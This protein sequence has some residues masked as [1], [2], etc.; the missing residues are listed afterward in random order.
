MTKPIPD[1][2][3]TLTPHIVVTDGAQAIEFYKQAFGAQEMSR[4]MTPDGKAMMH[5][6]MKIGDSILMMGGE[7]PPNCLSPKSRGGTSV[8]LHIYLADADAAFDRAVKAGC[9]V[10]MPVSDMFWGDRYGVVED[11]FGHQW[12]IA[13]HK[14]DYTHE[15]IAANAKD[16]FEKMPKM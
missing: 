8:S 2:F 3:H 4:L 13:T 14:H 9:T 7:F 11:P 1:G 5:A 6:Q 16:F 12:S 15:Q 10:K